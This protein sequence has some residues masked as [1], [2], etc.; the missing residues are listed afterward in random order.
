MLYV[1]T[2]IL[3][4]IFLSH[5]FLT[6]CSEQEWLLRDTALT[7]DDA[8][9]DDEKLNDVDLKAGS[10]ETFLIQVRRVSPSLT[11]YMYF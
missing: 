6:A 8:V 11:D 5:I 9:A 4:H 7:S 2:C 3:S 1:Y 10:K